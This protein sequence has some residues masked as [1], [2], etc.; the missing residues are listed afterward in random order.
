MHRDQAI[1]DEG[2]YV[3]ISKREHVISPVL[4]RKRYADLLPIEKRDAIREAFVEEFKKKNYD[5]GLTRAVE[6]IERSLQG[7]SGAVQGGKSAG[8]GA[9]SGSTSEPRAERP[10]PGGRPWAHSC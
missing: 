10:R 7:A 3:L 2:I 6:T 1:Q 4:V 9:G 8:W 5:G